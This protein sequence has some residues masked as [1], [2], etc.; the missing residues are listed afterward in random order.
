MSDAEVDESLAYGKTRG[1][2]S[3]A[4]MSLIAKLDSTFNIMLDIE[5]VLDLSSYVKA[6]EI[7]V[8]YGVQF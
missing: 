7:L 3:F 2:D 6:R 5:D 4:H 8:K 1:W